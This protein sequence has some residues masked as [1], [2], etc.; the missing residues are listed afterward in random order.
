MTLHKCLIKYNEATNYI[1]DG[2]VLLFR[3]TSLISMLIQA[4]GEG[5]YSHAALA[6]WSRNEQGERERLECIEFREWIGSRVISLEN[7]V[8]SNPGII[9]VFR[10]VPKVY[11]YSYNCKMRDLEVQLKTFNS[12]SIISEFRSLTGLPYGWGR[13]WWLAKYHMIG[14]RLFID[15]NSLDDSP[16]PKE[17]YPVCS[18]II[19]HL[20]SKHYVDLIKFRSDSR[21]EPNDLARSPL[22]NYLFT[23]VP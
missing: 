15:N 22:L 20:F 21:T 5:Y 13:I 18:T 7:Y 6:T 11:V 1:Q 19:S 14:L 10:P 4:V 9:D 8:N 23:L 2:D 16:A 12:K 3:G 17:I